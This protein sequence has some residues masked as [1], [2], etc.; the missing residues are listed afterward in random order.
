MVNEKIQVHSKYHAKIR[1]EIYY[2]NKF[3]LNSH[4]KNINIKIDSTK[5]LNNLYG[6]ILYVLSINDN[7]EE[8]KK[9]KQFINELK[10]TRSRL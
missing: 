1:Q 3:G 6:R 10:R 2:I 4:L 8:F 7:D 5:Y 9:Y